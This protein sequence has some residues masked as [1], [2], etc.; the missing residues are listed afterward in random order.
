M[1]GSAESSATP[2]SPPTRPLLANPYVELGFD[3][4]GALRGG[5]LLPEVG[6]AHRPPVRRPSGYVETPEEDADR[7]RIVV[8]PIQPKGASSW[9]D[10]SSGISGGRRDLE[11]ED[12]RAWVWDHLAGA[13]AASSE[14]KRGAGTIAQ[15]VLLAD[16]DYR[17]P[18]ESSSSEEEDWHRTPPVR[19]ARSRSGA[20]EQAQVLSK[21]AE[22]TKS[23]NP[24]AAPSVV[25]EVTRGK[26]PPD[27]K[28]VSRVSRVPS[29]QKIVPVAPNNNDLLSKDSL[30]SSSSSLHNFSRNPFLTIASQSPPPGPSPTQEKPKNRG[31]PP[32]K[33]SS[34]SVHVPHNGRGQQHTAGTA[35]ASTATSGANF[36]HPTTS[37]EASPTSSKERS[38]RVGRTSLEAKN[39]DA[40]FADLRSY[41]EGEE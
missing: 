35:T 7:D 1:R 32:A 17:D 12:E 36:I 13:A 3:I 27:E 18:W 20:P 40:A 10:A 4:E 11:A 14:E 39:M 15:E 16:P 25:E 33:K 24:F 38:D 8:L 23:R 5:R 37:S 19:L 41:V 6:V 28:S 21:L 26:N 34:D 22:T 9:R 2:D 31:E 30:N 29:S